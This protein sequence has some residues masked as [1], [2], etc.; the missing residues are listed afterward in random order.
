MD[1]CS[2]DV[3]IAV[4]GNKY[5]LYYEER[6]SEEKAAKFGYSG[7]YSYLRTLEHVI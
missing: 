1:N 2:S 7:T 3:V 6:V 4:A 5:D